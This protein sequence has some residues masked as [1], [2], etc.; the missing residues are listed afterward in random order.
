M[1]FLNKQEQEIASRLDNG[2]IACHECGV[3]MSNA[4]TGQL[5]TTINS[6]RAMLTAPNRPAE[7]LGETVVIDTKRLMQDN[8]SLRAEVKALREALLN[9]S[10]VGSSANKLIDE[11]DAIAKARGEHE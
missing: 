2:I 8:A 3:V 5:L 11:A 6:L 10:D 7:K 9:V 1:K 4:E